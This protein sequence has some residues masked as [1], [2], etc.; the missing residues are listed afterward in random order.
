MAACFDLGEMFIPDHPYSH[1]MCGSVVAATP[2]HKHLVCAL[3]QAA[4]RT[5][6]HLPSYR[7]RV[8][9][10]VVDM[11]SSRSINII[12][13]S[14]MDDGALIVTTKILV[15][16]NPNKQFQSAGCSGAFALFNNVIPG[17]QPP[18]I[19]RSLVSFVEA[20]RCPVC[21]QTGALGCYCS[22]PP[23]THYSVIPD[24]YSSSVWP[25]RIANDIPLNQIDTYH[26]I[27]VRLDLIQ[28]VAHVK[29]T[30]HLVTTNDMLNTGAAY[31]LGPSRFVVKA[32]LFRPSNMFEANTL[33]QVAD[34]LRLLRSG[35][36]SLASH[37]NTSNSQSLLFKTHNLAHFPQ[38]QVTAHSG[39]EET[40]NTAQ[41]HSSAT[42]TELPHSLLSTQITGAHVL[43]SESSQVSSAYKSAVS[44]AKITTATVSATKS[45]ISRSASK[46]TEITET[47]STTTAQAVKKLYC[48]LCDK[49]F[50]QQG[51]LNR[52]LKNIHEEQKIP[53]QYCSMVFGQ[54]FDLKVSHFHH[55]NFMRRAFSI[56][57][58]FFISNL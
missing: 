17:G 28:H 12:E 35:I 11:G 38:P 5:S 41:I 8:R 15:P 49:T 50:S 30:A 42:L 48:Q 31:K 34:K 57:K 24:D 7:T 23:I 52:H 29:I 44:R 32:V 56:L 6:E 18:L 26:N 37:T 54:M 27:R 45:G 36:L 51:S 4:S 47:P 13:F 10:M 22:S 20:P 21:T 25:P 9:R 53:C 55:L 1:F 39:D 19:P 33:R 43:P 2:F 40:N 3:G 46:I 58:P 16:P 14:W